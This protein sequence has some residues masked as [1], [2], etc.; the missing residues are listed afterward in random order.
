MDTGESTSSHL[1]QPIREPYNPRFSTPNYAMVCDRFGVHKRVA[2][3]LATALFEDMG[4]KDNQGNPLIMDKNKIS[5]EIAK[6]REEVLRKRHDDS[7]L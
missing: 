6:C 5:R 7:T 3:A 2:S 1:P 4:I